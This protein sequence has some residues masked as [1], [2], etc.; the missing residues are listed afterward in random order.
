M[1]APG[2]RGALAP[3]LRCRGTRV[4]AD[5]LRQ[6]RSRGARLPGT[7]ADPAAAAERGGHPQGGRGARRVRPDGD[8]GP[9]RARALRAE[10]RRRLPG[11]DAR[12]WR[13]EMR[14][15]LAAELGQSLQLIALSALT[16][17]VYLGLGLLAVRLLG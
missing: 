3:P 13:R 4:R 8:L 17:A 1:G 15:P 5:V 11:R 16:M 10:P 9:G 7:P 12:R 2:R 6:G 14:G